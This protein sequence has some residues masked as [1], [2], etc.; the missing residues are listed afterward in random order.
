MGLSKLR[1]KIGL[2]H[3][4]VTVDLTVDS[5]LNATYSI[6]HLQ[7]KLFNYPNLKFN[8]LIFFSLANN[9]T[10]IVV[11]FLDDFFSSY[12][13]QYFHLFKLKTNFHIHLDYFLF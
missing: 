8:L 9:I 1:E 2:K 7:R 3:I 10:L 6:H 5:S 4:V 11:S 12:F 13:A